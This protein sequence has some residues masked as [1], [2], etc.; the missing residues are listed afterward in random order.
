M[1]PPASTDPCGFAGLRRA[2]RAVCHLYDLVLAPTQLKITQ[3]TM[4]RQ[5]AD[6]GEIAHCDL[7]RKCVGSEETFS[8]R[9]ASARKCGWVSMRVGDR[10]RRVY[11]LTEKGM[12]V[13]REATPYWERAQDRMPVNWATP[14]GRRSSLWHSV[15]PTPP[16]APRVLLTE[17]PG[18]WP[19]IP[20]A[21]G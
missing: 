7:A 11:R 9:L 6:A 12:Q 5:I 16:F 19:S 3:Y 21:P 1:I 10:Q 4:L 2:S 14:T 8:R 13:L 20:S 17:T 15:S 18:P